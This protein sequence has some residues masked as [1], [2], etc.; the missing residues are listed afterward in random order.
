MSSIQPFGTS[1]D[2]ATVDGINS[3]SL[4]QIKAF[5]CTVVSFDISA[6]WSSQAGSLSLNLIED[7][8]DGDRL[9]IPVIGSP[10]IF[11]VRED[12]GSPDGKVIFEHIGLVESF[13]RSASTTTKTY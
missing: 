5:G 1:A 7:E 6:D 3:V 4:K 11:E 10:F 2:G 8:A 12:D 13:S 9:S